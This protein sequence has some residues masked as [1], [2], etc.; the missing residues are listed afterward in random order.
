MS[1]KSKKKTQANKEEAKVNQNKS[2]DRDIIVKVSEN[3]S[4]RSILIKSYQDL[5]QVIL[6]SSQ[7]VF[8]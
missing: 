6:S 1:K 3:E 7:E 8:K 2:E 5:L 4:N